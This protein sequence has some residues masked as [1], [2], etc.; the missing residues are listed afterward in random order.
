MKKISF[1]GYLVRGCGT[2]PHCGSHPGTPFLIF[3][4]LMGAAA[5]AKGGWFGALVGAGVML[6]V[7]GSC[8]LVGAY[9]RSK[10]E[11]R[12]ERFHG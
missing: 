1:I 7:F 6:I 11:E 2:L 5:G 8:Y 9:G 10:E 4:A 3:F 12:A